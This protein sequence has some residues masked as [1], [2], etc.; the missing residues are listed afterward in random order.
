MSQSKKI[1][2]LDIETSPL[3][4]YTWGLF[5]QNIGL[6]QIKSDWSIL[7]WAAKWVGD[8]ASKTIYR[9]NRKSRVLSDDKALVKELAELIEKADGV[10][11]QNGKAFDM[12]KINARAA[13][14]KLPPIRTPEHTD[15]L[16]ETK[17]VFR[18]TSHKL[19]YMTDVLNS[20]YKKLDHKEYPGFSLWSAILAGDKKA[21]PV[22]QKYCIHDV[23]STE[24]TY[25]AIRKWIKDPALYG[26]EKCRHCSSRK[27]RSLGLRP[28]KKGV[29]RRLNCMVCGAPHKGEIA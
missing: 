7:A 21:W 16:R 24:E 19:E 5:Q 15:I 17:K 4:S 11:T 27:F 6:N 25:L 29:Y 3:T 10:V 22:M 12:K 13:I 23:L 18:F 20:K 8:P 2:C 26:K 28:T 9:D 1:L 14:H